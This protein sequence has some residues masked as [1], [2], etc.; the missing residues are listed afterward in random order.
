MGNSD[1]YERWGNLRKGKDE[2]HWPIYFYVSDIYT[3][4]NKICIKSI[5]L[6]YANNKVEEQYGNR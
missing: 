3:A 2:F 5:F 1:D 4:V 6:L